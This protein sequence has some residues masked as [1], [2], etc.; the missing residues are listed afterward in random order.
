LFDTDRC[1][2]RWGFVSGEEHEAIRHSKEGPTIAIDHDD[3]G[4]AIDEGEIGG[5]L[6]NRPSPPD[7]HNVSFLHS[8]VDYGVP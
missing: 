1:A 6:T 7:G 3:S 2:K 8:R 5:H 4:S